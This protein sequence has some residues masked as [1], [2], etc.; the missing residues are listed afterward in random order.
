MP[1]EACLVAKAPAVGP[2]WPNCPHCQGIIDALPF[3]VLLV[4]EN[5]RILSANQKV[6]DTYGPKASCGAFCPRVIHGVDVF[7]GCPLERAVVEA[8][9]IEIEYRDPES[10]RWWASAIYPT[11]FNAETGARV[12]LHFARDISEEKR[13]AA[14]LS[15]SLE[16]HQA[17]A[18]LLQRLNASGSAEQCLDALLDVT[19][20]LSWMGLG[21]RAMAFLLEGGTLALVACRN[22]DPAAQARCRRVPRGEC[23]CGRAAE[24]ARPLFLS[25]AELARADLGHLGEADH[26]HAS[27]PLTHEGRVLGV[28]TFY[29][30]ADQ[31]LDGHQTSFL[32][33]AAGVAAATI[34]EQLSRR[35]ARD[36]QERANVLER[37]LLERV[38]ETQEDER[39]RLA[40]DLHD[41]LGQALSVLLLELASSSP[42][43]LSPEFRDHLAESLREL[44]GKVYGLS[45]NLRPAILDDLGLDSA[46]A[47]YIAGLSER[48]GLSVDYQFVCPP[49]LDSRLPSGVELTL[50]RVTQEALS[51]VARH[52]GASRASVIVLRGQNEATLVVEDDGR[53]F[54]VKAIRN[55]QGPG[56]LGLT[57]M[58]ERLELVN[59]KL[60]IDSI[61]GQGTSIKATIPLGP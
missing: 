19:L 5:H 51:N 41:D 44:T 43:A 23:V 16:H 18:Q 42:G 38:L 31:H 37:K 26:G 17:L 29:L 7:A 8:R 13:V 54:D 39:K 1:P 14:E 55:L 46:I 15:R 33:A 57:G 40:R 9:P 28:A 58:Q 52:A 20:G 53:G 34:A 61:P 48:M 50:Y 10:A 35:E 2:S 11:E 59:G 47:H 27:M 12:Y 32:K 60:V 45:R 49:G 22:V 21:K 36:A 24:T 56:G 3:Y 6:T 4:D 30:E 25:R